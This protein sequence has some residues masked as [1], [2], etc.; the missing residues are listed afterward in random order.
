MQAEWL[1]PSNL[2][3]GMKETSQNYTAKIKSSNNA[4][5]EVHSLCTAPDPS[6]LYGI[7]Q[8]ILKKRLVGL[9]SLKYVVKCQ[10]YNTL[11]L[12]MCG[13]DETVVTANLSQIYFGCAAYA[14]GCSAYAV[15]CATYDVVCPEYAVGCA[16]YVYT[17]RIKLTQSS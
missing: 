6:L 11:T 2:I 12:D 3:H 8:Y 5:V 7:Q 10:T 17:V 13:K 15:G 1:L 14:F 4:P 16:A 9:T